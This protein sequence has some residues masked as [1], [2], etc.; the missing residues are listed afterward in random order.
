M[1]AWRATRPYGKEAFTFS[2]IVNSDGSGGM[3]EPA[4]NMGLPPNREKA[5]NVMELA[6]RLAPFTA[7]ATSPTGC[8]IEFFG[9]GQAVATDEEKRAVAALANC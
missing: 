2:G 8:T 5:A 4:G 3:R 1:I 6:E 7:T 9:R